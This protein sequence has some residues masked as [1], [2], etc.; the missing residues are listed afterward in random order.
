MDRIAAR[1]RVVDSVRPRSNARRDAAPV[2]AVPVMAVPAMMGESAQV[3]DL[4]CGDRQAH[5]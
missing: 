5:G 2:M 1:F 4:G 3:A